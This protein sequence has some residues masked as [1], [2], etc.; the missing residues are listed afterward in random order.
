MWPTTTEWRSVKDDVIE[1]LNSA[2]ALDAVFGSK[3]GSVPRINDIWRM[4]SM[5]S[6][7]EDETFYMSLEENGVIS[8]TARQM[9][10]VLKDWVPNDWSK[11]VLSC[12]WC[13]AEFQTLE[14][15]ETHEDIC[16]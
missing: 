16:S 6:D 15:L 4:R 10:E 9:Q 8:V 5:T 13:A 14:E 12:M 11:A 1:Y 3:Q 2:V 7:P